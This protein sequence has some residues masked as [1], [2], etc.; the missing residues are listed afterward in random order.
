MTI[1]K[2]EEMP[3]HLACK[4]NGSLHKLDDGENLISQMSNYFEFLSKNTFNK[5]PLWT[6]PYLD[7]WG[8][9][10]MVTVAIPAISK[11]TGR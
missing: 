8:L 6:A 5:E 10:L 4:N 11:V 1:D 2:G 7:A 9:G 3:G